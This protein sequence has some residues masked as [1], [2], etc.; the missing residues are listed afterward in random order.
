MGEACAS[1]LINDLTVLRSYRLCLSLPVYPLHMFDYQVTFN[2][3]IIP[4]VSLIFQRHPTH[5]LSNLSTYLIFLFNYSPI[6]LTG[7]FRDEEYETM[8]HPSPVINGNS[9]VRCII[10]IIFCAWVLHK[11]CE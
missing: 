6:T 7:L 9:A 2:K 1:V 3:I 10:S 5:I 4:V 11:H 8:D